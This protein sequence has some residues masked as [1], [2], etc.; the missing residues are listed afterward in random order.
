MTWVTERWRRPASLAR[1]GLTAII[2]CGLL[3]ACSETPKIGKTAD[4]QSRSIEEAPAGSPAPAAPPAPE[5][6]APK[7][8][9][10]E[11]SDAQEQS[12][13]SSGSDEKPGTYHYYRKKKAAAPD[14]D[15]D[16]AAE[17]P[18]SEPSPAGAARTP[19][20]ESAGA[21]PT[22]SPSPAPPPPPPVVAMP[23]PAAPG[24][25]GRAAVETDPNKKYKVVPV[26][27]GTDRAV[28]PDPTRLQF[29][30][31]RG[32]KLQLGRAL[33]TVPFSHEVPHIERPR[34]IEIP[35]FKI[36]IY[37]EKEDPDKHFTV[38]EITSLTEDQMLALVKEQLAKSSTFKNHAFVFI[39]GFNTSFDCALYRT[40]QIAYDLGFDGVPFLYSW[41]SGGNVA[42]YTYD[43][44]SVEQAEPMLA[45]FLDMVIQKSGA[46]SISLIAHSMGNELLLRVL[47]RLRPKIPQGVVISQV[48]L[49]APDVDRDKFNIIA[50]EITDFAKGV[51]LYA[52]SND[53]ALGY[54]QRFWGGVPRAGD[55]PKDGPLIIPG[56]DTIDVTAV[57]TDALGLNHSGY[58]ENPALLDDVK[59]LVEFGVRP[60]DKRL[61]SILAVESPGGMYWRFQ[62]TN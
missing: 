25:A 2:A 47:E 28:E 46:K 31:D 20:E 39:H 26:F 38:Q 33:I 22:A 59:A 32:H 52:A 23:P 14:E 29:S 43:H 10:P 55:V 4:N 24:A 21:A 6:S 1:I 17:P 30:S 60:P 44:G 62:A 49:A 5:A 48:I 13:A 12:Q 15:A 54:S 36:K 9:A 53:R 27:Y 34:V 41:P 61:K 42:S 40:A 45:E 8:A 56:V 51:T 16:T 58:A 19:E 35:Y 7:P 11:Q 3:T 37:A 50:R 18:S 57:S